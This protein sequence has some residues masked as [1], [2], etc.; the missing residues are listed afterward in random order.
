MMGTL[1][2]CFMTL[3]TTNLTKELKYKSIPTKLLGQSIMT[4]GILPIPNVKDRAQ[5]GLSWFLHKAK[6]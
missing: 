3:V 5:R 1:P 2:S 6:D 4:L